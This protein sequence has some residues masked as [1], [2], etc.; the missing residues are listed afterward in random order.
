M[1]WQVR[2]EVLLAADGSHAGA[3]AT[4]RDAERL[5]EVEVDDIRAVVA[6]STEADLG[7][8]VG[9]IDV[10]LTTV[11]MHDIADLLDALL[12]HSMSRWVG[13]HQCSQ[14]IFVSLRFFPKIIHINVS[15]VI[16]FHDFHLHACH[17][18]AGRISAM[19]G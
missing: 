13:H 8:H 17:Y 18:A 4:V 7:V 9:A 11:L 5:M 3:T 6:G 14:F 1:P 19:S 10:D 15:V 16:T 2:T 12:E